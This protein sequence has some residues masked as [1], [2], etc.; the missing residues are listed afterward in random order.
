MTFVLLPS[1]LLNFSV[2]LSMGSGGSAALPG[3]N[4]EDCFFVETS[5][6]RN[7]AGQLLRG[8]LSRLSGSPA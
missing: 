6:S 3:D 2:E 5:G 4:F 7:E 8:A 1:R